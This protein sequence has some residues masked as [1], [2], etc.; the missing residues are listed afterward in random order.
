MVLPVPTAMAPWHRGTVAWPRIVRHFQ[1]PQAIHRVAEARW[2]VC[3]GTG[4]QARIVGRHVAIEAVETPADCAVVRRALAAG[5]GHGHPQDEPL[6]FPGGCDLVH[7]RGA[8]ADGIILGP[9]SL[10]LAH[11]PDEYVP[12]AELVNAAAIYR[13]IALGLLGRG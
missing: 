11:K 8:G 5:T 6:G 2:L 3:G 1:L 10:D 12:E 13:D 4:V 9:G 7:F